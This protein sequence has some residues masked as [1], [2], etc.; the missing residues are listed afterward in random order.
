M[1]FIILIAVVVLFHE[2]GHFLVAKLFGI[3]VEEFSI[4]FPPK[5]ISKKIGETEYA[6][7]LL[8]V[9]G[10]VK[11]AGQDDF[12]KQQVNIEDK[13]MYYSKPAW[14][15]FLVV[16][17]GPFF[18]FVIGWILFVIIFTNGINVEYNPNYPGKVG[19]VFENSAA[20]EAGV[21]PGDE[22][23]Q[24]GKRKIT[25]WN[26]LLELSVNPQSDEYEVLIK[27]E[28]QLLTKKI[29]P[30]KSGKRYLFGIT[31]YLEPR[32]GTIIEQQKNSEARNLPLKPNDLIL[33][34]DY[35]P[36]KQWSA[37]DEYLFLNPN[38]N[39]TAT[40]KRNNEIINVVIT[41]EKNQKENIGYLD[42]ELTK[43]NGG[44]FILKPLIEKIDNTKFENI[45]I[46]AGDKII[47]VVK[48]KS[49]NNSFDGA[50]NLVFEDDFEYKINTGL[51]FINFVAAY[52][53]EYLAL[54]LERN[55]E[56]IKRVV[57]TQVKNLEYGTL[58]IH[59]IQYIENYNF[60]QAFKKSIEKS[61]D[62][63]ISTI[64]VIGKIFTNKMQ[65]RDVLGGPITMWKMTVITAEAGYNHFLMLMAIISINL[66]FINLLPI[67]IIDGG[68]LVIY[69]YEMLSGKMP[70]E[71]TLNF[72]QQ[73]GL[74][75]V[76]S[77]MIFTFYIDIIKMF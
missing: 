13:G 65:A 37:I 34:L 50:E 1:P 43:S 22:I 55:G 64:Q 25:S 75:I 2:L 16:F 26:D 21:Q 10:Y 20:A 33:A 12:G 36:I 40:I 18:N 17:A 3:R 60:T 4:G 58:D 11:L 28:E 9:G 44:Y 62:F 42:I 48:L 70:S 14:Q 31:Q 39:I 8:P 61:K 51:E 67:P 73:A 69:I 19:Y 15:R 24:V 56:I 38:K 47:S 71:K 32:I 59:P 49:K 30:R 57:K 74:V 5:L 52:P 76:I 27:R 77:L 63:I 68:H 7:S 23:I 6:I 66:G 41:P 54:V 46:Q 35:I 29:R 45:D 53:N 72:I